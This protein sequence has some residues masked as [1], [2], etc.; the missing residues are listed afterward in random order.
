MINGV[1]KIHKNMQLI[2]KHLIFSLI[3]VAS[4]ATLGSAQKDGPILYDGCKYQK[5]EGLAEITSVR[6]VNTAQASAL[7]YEEYEVLYSFLPMDKNKPTE[8]MASQPV[9]LREGSYEFPLNKAYIEKYAI[10]VG[11]KVPMTFWYIKKG[12]CIPTWYT[13]AGLPNDLSVL[14]DQLTTLKTKE[15]ER[16]M[17]QGNQIAE[18]TKEAEIAAN[19]TITKVT[20]PIKETKAPKKAK[21]EAATTQVA[22]EG[23]TKVTT[24]TPTEDL[25][26][27]K[28]M[29]EKINAEP[30]AIKNEQLE[31]TTEV[32]TKTEVTQPND[33]ERPFSNVPTKAY[34][35]VVSKPVIT[36]NT[37]TGPILY[38][39]CKY[40]KY[41]GLAEITSVQVL[42][43]AKNSAL[44]YDEYEIRYAFA[45]IDAKVKQTPEMLD[46]TFTL[47]DGTFEYLANKE[48]IS[49]YALLVGTKVPMTFWLMKKGTCTP[50]WCYS[51]GMPNDLS[52]FGD[53]LL[54]LK[55]KEL[56]RRME[57]GNKIAEQTSESIKAT[58]PQ[59]TVTQKEIVKPRVL[60]S[61]ATPKVN[62]EVELKP[63]EN[64]TFDDKYKEVDP[65]KNAKYNAA[66]GDGGEVSTVQVEPSVE[67]TPAT[68]PATTEPTR[69]N[70][71]P[72]P[73]RTVVQAT[74]PAAD[75]TT[76]TA[77]TLPTPTST[78]DAVRMARER[79]EQA[80]K[81]QSESE[82]K[83][84]KDEQQRLKAVASNLNDKTKSVQT[85]TAPTITRPV[86]APPMN[87]KYTLEEE[88]TLKVI[89]VQKITPTELK[90]IVKFTPNNP[91]AISSGYWFR[92]QVL[93]TTNG[94]NP[95]NEFVRKNKLYNGVEIKATA[96]MGEGNCPPKFVSPSIQD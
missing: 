62:Q 86:A 88:G 37:A 13:S 38:D 67:Q 48:Y 72:S 43:S 29:F 55:N 78:K 6:V 79:R 44:G 64:I 36:Y 1:L 58:M 30:I 59:P 32:A 84:Q 63:K 80:L 31:T 8:A 96:A 17:Q 60:P 73:K 20:E 65:T 18:Q 47:R 92:N 52:V 49:K 42:Q 51:T 21:T 69:N 54:E 83:Q 2:S 85:T 24:E 56:Q 22:P 40:Q 34:E 66:S 87:C 82:L 7:G 94:L 10:L 90:I 89:E 33:N 76:P 77:T 75:A 14:G 11:T 74:I 26:V 70:T 39:G 68:E 4:I 3:L 12:T 16:R 81:K 28:D 15:L 9:L 41:E 25:P 50:S 91:Q 45:P 5:C 35:P 95:S 93:T 27:N 53:N 23:N 61:V 71:T 46:Q 57:A 19:T